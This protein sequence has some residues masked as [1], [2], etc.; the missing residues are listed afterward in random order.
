MARLRDAKGR[1]MK[2]TV[3]EA[4]QK[5]LEAV[6]NFLLR[7]V[8]QP[9]EKVAAE[10]YKYLTPASTSGLFTARRLVRNEISFTFNQ[11]TKDEAIQFDQLVKYNTTGTYK[12]SIDNGV[13]LVHAEGHSEGYPKGVYLPGEVPVP[14]THVNCRCFLTPVNLPREDLAITIPAPP[15]TTPPTTPIDEGYKGYDLSGMSEKKAE[16]FQ[17]AIDEGW[18]TEKQLKEAIQRAKEEWAHLNAPK[19]EPTVPTSWKSWQVRLVEALNR[20]EAEIIKLIERPSRDWTDSLHKDDVWVLKNWTVYGFNQINDGLRGHSRVHGQLL[21]NVERMDRVLDQA[22][23]YDEEIVVYRGLSKKSPLHP[24]NDPE[25][26]L[27][28]T[29]PAFVSTSTKIKV[30]HQFANDITDGAVIEIRIPAGTKVPYI[31]GISTRRD[32]DEVLLPRRTTFEVIGYSEQGNVTVIVVPETEMKPLSENETLLDLR[33]RAEQ[34]LDDAEY[35]VKQIVAAYADEGY[36]RF[37]GFLRSGKEPTPEIARALERI[38]QFLETAP[39]STRPTILYRGVSSRNPLHPNNLPDIGLRV[40]DPAYVSTSVKAG[41]ARFFAD[42]ARDGDVV[43]ITVPAGEPLPFI[44]R[45]AKSKTEAEVLLPRNATFEVTGRNAD[46]RVTVEYKKHKIKAI[47]APDDLSGENADNGRLQLTLIANDA[48]KPI[49]V[50]PLDDERVIPNSDL[51]EPA[52]EPAKTLSEAEKRARDLG[53]T[54]LDYGYS[55]FGDNSRSE[56]AEAYLNVANSTN[57]ALEQVISRG[58]SIP[59]SIQFREEFWNKDTLAYYDTYTEGLVVNL[60]SRVGDNDS[61]SVK[62]L[63]EKGWLVSET[64]EDVLLHELGHFIHFNMKR[65][66]GAGKDDFL[67]DYQESLEDREIMMS[68]SDY[69]TADLDEYV[70]EAFTY[71]MKGNKLT[72]DQQRLYDMAGGPPVSS[73]TIRTVAFKEKKK[74]ERSIPVDKQSSFQ[75]RLRNP[76]DLPKEGLRDPSDPSRRYFPPAPRPKPIVREFTPLKTLDATMKQ[77]KMLGVEVAEH[78][79]YMDS[80]R[81]V[82]R[83]YVKSMHIV[84]RALHQM[85]AEG[86]TLPRAVRIIREPSLGDMIAQYDDHESALIINMAHPMWESKDVDAEMMSSFNSGFTV[87]SNVEEA[88]IHEMGHHLHA[89]E[90][91]PLVSVKGGPKRPQA[92]EYVDA[93]QNEADW[94]IAAEISEYA[95]ATPAEFVAEAYTKLRSGKKLTAKQLALYK[96]L[97]G[98]EV[99]S[100]KSPVIQRTEKFKE[101]RKEARDKD[102]K[103]LSYKGFD[104]SGLSDNSKDLVREAVDSGWLTNEQIDRMI[105]IERTSVEEVVVP[106]RVAPAETIAEALEYARDNFPEVSVVYDSRKVSENR[107]LGALN[108]LNNSLQELRDKN[109]NISAKMVLRDDHRKGGEAYARYDPDTKEI[110][111]NLSISMWEADNPS[112]ET[113]WFVSQNMEQIIWHELGHARHFEQLTRE[114]KR[115][116]DRLAPG[117]DRREQDRIMSTLSPYASTRSYEFVA[118][119]YTRQ[120]QGFE[121]TLEQQKLY[122]ALKGPRIN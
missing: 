47:K 95:A 113:N 89:V 43:E 91:F 28:V 13:C 34:W 5:D 8:G 68:I 67:L 121:L 50:P 112:V 69:A 114:E 78:R 108:K 49:E 55:I 94:V 62:E 105:E 33:K 101:K 38:D 6:E 48:L 61:S 41:T 35:G 2:Q 58:Y 59:K 29:D 98:P 81:Q 36:E 30:A 99:I 15:K 107:V 96:K 1:F 3:K 79:D 86:H 106:P 76:Q 32:E 37:N 72:E 54:D 24:S 118:E 122:E 100:D 45:I 111:I 53:V 14:P 77:I 102:A 27:R 20:A 44:E 117:F 46:G 21:A 65:P 83:G 82:R 90:N 19:P 110:V 84:S 97:N 9:R 88:I 103:T 39:M 4:K 17:R 60:A 87:A 42:M 71:Q 85:A 10:L 18:L 57:A 63:H 73:A 56:S 16:T 66:D 119:A 31:Q 104:L 52:P 7:R 12:P 109:Q 120:L 11:A 22:P 75:D 26:G 116:L 74:E 80:S 40:T 64:V 70:A 92:P 51:P 23:S 25:L 93:W 115:D